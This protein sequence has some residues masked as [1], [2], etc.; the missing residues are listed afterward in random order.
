MPDPL[1]FRRL[2]A[3]ETN[4]SDLLEYLTDRDPT[5]WVDLA[6]GTVRAGREARI[7]RNRRADLM[8]RGTEGEATGGVEVKLGHTFEE[9]QAVAYETTLDAGE[10]LLLLGLDVDAEAASA[11]G[12]RWQFVHLSTLVARWAASTDPEAAAVASAMMR[13][14]SHRDTV[15]SGVLA[16][17]DGEKPLSSIQEPF[18]ARVV[19]RAIRG[20]LDMHDGI[21]TYTG[22]TLGGGNAIL[23][24]FRQIPGEDEGRDFLAEVRWSIPRQT[25]VLRFGL[26]FP[27]GTREKRQAAWDAAQRMDKVIAAN[28]FLAHLEGTAPERAGHVTAKGTGRPR[29]KGDWNEIVAEGFVPGDGKFYNPGFFR[30]GDTRLEAKCTIDVRGTSGSDL[31]PLLIAGLDYLEAHWRP[32]G[33]TS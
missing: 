16:T 1:G 22:V 29:P 28:R 15:V 8:L 3:K 2:M 9:G 6:P 24:A 26:D 27:S 19:T 32:A 21:R 17:G 5:P 18:E 23:M 11:T 13:V 10:P 7:G 31:E 30:D 33:G 4:V 12:E 25:M 20:R 14:L